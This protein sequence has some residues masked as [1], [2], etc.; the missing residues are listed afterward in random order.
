MGP[1]YRAVS[2]A[3]GC[4]A[5]RG[6]DTLKPSYPTIKVR[7]DVKDFILTGDW[8]GYVEGAD[9][10]EYGEYLTVKLR[11]SKFEPSGLRTVD[12]N[13]PCHASVNR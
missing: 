1:F 9:K 4:R 3:F 6:E 10:D 5:T 12:R 11:R 2:R 7:S 8:T 13:N